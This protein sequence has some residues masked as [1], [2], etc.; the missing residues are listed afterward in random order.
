VKI[1]TR[2]HAATQ[3]PPTTAMSIDA[4]SPLVDIRKGEI[5]VAGVRNEELTK[6]WREMGAWAGWA[7]NWEKRGDWAPLAEYI[8]EGGE[9]S[10]SIRAVLV[11][12]L[13]GKPRPNNRAQSHR[14]FFK[15]MQRATFAF[16]QQKETGG[17]RELAIDKAAEHFGVDR[18]T[19]Q[20]DLKKLGL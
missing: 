2:K 20:R 15:S 4:S 1:G 17:K 9:I 14:V 18:R 13:R 7:L 11:T 12:I 6:Q 10:D 8:E 16:F 19:I 5:W 3:G